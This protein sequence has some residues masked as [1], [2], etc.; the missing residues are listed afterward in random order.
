MINTFNYEVV[1]FMTVRHEQISLQ[2][3][4]P[5]LGPRHKGTQCRC[6]INLDLHERGVTV[7]IIFHQIDLHLVVHTIA[8]TN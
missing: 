1:H 7:C 4:R 8:I 2:E 6:S 3:E 5:L